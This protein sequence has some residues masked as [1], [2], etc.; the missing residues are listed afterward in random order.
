MLR[1]LILVTENLIV[2][3][4]TV[5]MLFAFI[6]EL[7]NRTGKYILLGGSLLGIA[8]AA[9]MAVIKNTT[10]KIHTGMW[11][12][13]VFAVA[14]SNANVFGTCAD[15]DLPERRFNICAFYSH[16]SLSPCVFTFPVSPQENSNRTKITFR[17]S[18]TLYFMY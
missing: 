14:G 12:L 5:G 10:A 18:V 1:Y 13:R 15:R 7:G 4:I 2:T 9:A 17:I 16:Y 3:A 11:N 6:N 8:G